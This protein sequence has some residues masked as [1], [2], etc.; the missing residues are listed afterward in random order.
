[1]R[2]P[3]RYRFL[4]RADARPYLVSSYLRKVTTQSETHHES[5]TP[6]ATITDDVRPVFHL[7]RVVCDGAE[8]PGHNRLHRHRLRL[9]IRGRAYRR[10]DFALFRRNDRRPILS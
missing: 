1:M 3:G 9:D 7:G 4:Y 2:G 10:N 5:D 6:S 8:L